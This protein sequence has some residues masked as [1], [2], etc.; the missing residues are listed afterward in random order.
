M[1]QSDIYNEGQDACLFV[2]RIFGVVGC[3]WDKET[4][5]C[6]AIMK[7][8]SK[9]ESSSTIFCYAFD[10]P[11]PHPTAGIFLIIYKIVCKDNLLRSAQQAL[12]CQS[13]KRKKIC[14]TSVKKNK[15]ILQ[16]AFPSC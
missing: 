4:E 13:M 10:D 5:H 8:T 15:L 3:Q 2:C 7:R 16:S 9:K 12:I 11:I 6:W 1:I 14:G